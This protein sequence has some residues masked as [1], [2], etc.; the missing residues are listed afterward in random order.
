MPNDE[1]LRFLTELEVVRNFG[2]THSPQGTGYVVDTLWSAKK[3]ME[4]NSFVD[5]VRTAI[6]F[7]NDTDSTA[8]VAGG[9]AGIRFGLS[10]IPVRWLSQLRGF[11][12]IGEIIRW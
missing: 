10:G 1:G 3:S 9:L 7:G 2:K 5:V 11:E 12:I 8:A 4:E 6:M